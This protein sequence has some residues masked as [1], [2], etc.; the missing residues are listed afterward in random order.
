MLRFI[1]QVW[2]LSYWTYEFASNAHSNAGESKYHSWKTQHCAGAVGQDAISID[3][4]PYY[5]DNVTLRP[6]FSE[7]GFHPDLI[8]SWDRQSS[9]TT[10][11]TSDWYPGSN[12]SRDALRK[13]S[14]RPVYRNTKFNKS[15]SRPNTSRYPRSSPQHSGHCSRLPLETLVSKHST[16][17]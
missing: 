7:R 4:N 14:S 13:S 6:L 8:K 15:S 16:E 9:V 17:E 1:L 11:C 12:S 2:P 5:P 3:A 10:V